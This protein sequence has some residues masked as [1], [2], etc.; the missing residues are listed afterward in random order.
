MK[1]L[2]DEFSDYHIHSSTFSD[3]LA[4]VEEIVRFAGEM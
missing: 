3:G 4:T 2:N 1:I